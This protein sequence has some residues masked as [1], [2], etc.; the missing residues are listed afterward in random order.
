MGGVQGGVFKLFCCSLLLIAANR[1]SIV[2]FTGDINM[3]SLT[4]GRSAL[5]RWFEIGTGEGSPSHW[6]GGWVL[7]VDYAMA[8]TCLHSA[9]EKIRYQPF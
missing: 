9:F 8:D 2:N 5:S 4:I 3:S 1:I 6:A 7:L